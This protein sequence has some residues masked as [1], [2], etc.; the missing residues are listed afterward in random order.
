MQ[1][2]LSIDWQLENPIILHFCFDF[3]NFFII[4]VIFFKTT[5]NMS[6]GFCSYCFTRKGKF[7][8]ISISYTKTILKE[9]P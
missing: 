9:P 6:G 4:K 7:W 3:L 1:L 2:I 5:L 8:V